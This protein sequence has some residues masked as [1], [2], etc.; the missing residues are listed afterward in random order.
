MKFDTAL[1]AQAS[2]V[3]TFPE[4]L[5]IFPNLPSFVVMLGQWSTSLQLLQT[6][7]SI[8][9]S[10]QIFMLQNTSHVNVG[11]DTKHYMKTA[12]VYAA[13]QS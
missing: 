3:R 11:S 12:Q 2:R 10:A 13:N 7:C 6:S 1:A 5:V 9:I 8:C 4:L